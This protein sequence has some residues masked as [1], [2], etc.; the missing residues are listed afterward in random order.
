[1]SFIFDDQNLIEQLLSS[2]LQDELKFTKRGQAAAGATD[3]NRTTLLEHIKNLQ[4][5]LQPSGVVKDP[6]AGPTIS[7]N[8]ATA[9][10]S[11]QLE[12]LG[13][14][15]QWLANNG[16]KVDGQVIAYVTKPADDENYILY[17]LETH[18]NTPQQRGQDPAGLYV[19]PNLLQK[20][21]VSLQAEE[22]QRP[23]AI[24]Q[25]ELSS[26]IEDANQALGLNIPTQYQAPEKVLPDAAIVDNV[27][28]IIDPVNLAATGNIP[29]TYGDLKDT[30]TFTAWLSKFNVSVKGNPV[31][32]KNPNYDFKKVIDAIV[33]RAQY[34]ITRA[35]D[36]AS[37]ERAEIYARA[38]SV[39]DGMFG[40]SKTSPTT[41]VDGSEYGQPQ[42][43]TTDQQGGP[44]HGQGGPN[45]AQAIVEAVSS[46]PFA[47]RDINFGRIENFFTKV[48]AAVGN[49][50]R[51]NNLITSTT[52][53]MTAVNN[54]VSAPDI[55]PMGLSPEDFARQFKNQQTPG[56]DYK[57]IINTLFQILSNTRMVAEYFWYLKASKYGDQMVGQIG[58]TPQDDSLYQQNVQ[59]LNQLNSAPMVS[60]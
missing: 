12:S 37:K 16:S 59:S 49:D 15:V 24:F 56:S 10:G 28:Q 22:T 44:N 27:P 35:V 40:N 60:K 7:H 32:V 13:D 21:I 57:P 1:M 36:A 41:S 39:L 17:K 18:T 26:L 43:G 38:A 55:F 51:I 53:L 54:K 45:A 29:L 48:K 42:R 30:T 33:A 8:G 2:G 9:L 11:P 5:Q 6:N 46:L 20:Y 4:D 23:N 52:N 34:L 31:Y 58:E 47:S 19:N 14:L 25:K 50:P 3:A